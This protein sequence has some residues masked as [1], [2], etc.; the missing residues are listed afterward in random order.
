MVNDEEMK[1]GRLRCGGVDWCR[2]KARILEKGL[3]F[4]LLLMGCNRLHTD[5]DRLRLSNQH[6]GD[7]G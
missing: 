6:V 1:K 2:G 7:P 5:P 4:V 3:D